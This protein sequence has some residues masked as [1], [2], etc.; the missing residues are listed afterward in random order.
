HTAGDRSPRDHHRE[1]RLICTTAKHDERR[2]DRE[3]PCDWRCVRK[4]EPAMTV[5]HSQTPRRQD[6]QAR[7]RKKD[8]DQA[9]RE[10]FRLRIETV[11]EQI[12]EVWRRQNAGEDD[13]RRDQYKQREHR[14]RDA[15]RFLLVVTSEELCVHRNERGGQRAFAED[16]LKEVGNSERGAER[17]RSV[18]SAEIVCKY[19]L[20]DDADD[21]ADQDAGAD[22]QRG[23]A[24]SFL[25]FF[26][27]KVSGRL[28]NYGTRLTRYRLSV[29]LRAEADLFVG[30]L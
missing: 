7:A 16:V 30:V 20:P 2:D 9:N 13:H 1:S 6:E 4:K 26:R 15:T 24:R 17:A 3:V 18:G 22:H 29:N 27:G 8:L 5:Q 19:S 23:T 21:A 12:D 11:G 28:A 10:R 14:V 25:G